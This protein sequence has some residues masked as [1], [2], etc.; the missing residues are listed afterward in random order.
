[1]DKDV[2]ESL[3]APL[4]HILR[5]AVDHGIEPPEIRAAGH[6]PEMGTILIEARQL[7]GDVQITIQDDGGGIDPNTILRRAVK[8]GVI[9]PDK[10][11]QRDEDIFALIAEPGFSTAEKVTEV[12]GRGVGMDVV[13]RYVEDLNGSL[14]ISSTLGLGT[15]MTLHIPM[16]LTIIEGMQVR[17]GDTNLTIPLINIREH[18]SGNGQDFSRDVDGNDHIMIRGQLVPVTRL[19]DFFDVCGDVGFAPHSAL[20]VVES[21][22]RIGALLVDEILGQCQTVIKRASRFLGRVHGVSGFSIL[23]DGGITMIVDVGAVLG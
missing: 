1:M 6:K 12:S 3:S 13:K 15:R 7:G 2:V 20:V 22:P 9:S 10:T 21:G 14:D 19:T 5:N 4:T 16:T 18:L 23:S 11:F 8:Q 17:V